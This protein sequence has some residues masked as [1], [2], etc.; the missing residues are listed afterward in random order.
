MSQTMPLL[1]RVSE[2]AYGLSQKDGQQVIV[3]NVPTDATKLSIKKAVES[4][5]E[6]KVTNIRTLN[7]KGRRIRTIRLGTKRARPGYG[8]RTTLKKAYVTLA[9]DSR[10]AI[11]DEPKDKKEAKK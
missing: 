8:Q 5:F 3:F 11:F 6:V 4:Q 10:I 1:H 7:A 2:K 9:A